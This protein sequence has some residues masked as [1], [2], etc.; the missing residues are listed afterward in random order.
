M[1][2]GTG[3][4]RGRRS[5]P[6]VL[7]G[8]DTLLSARGDDDSSAAAGPAAPQKSPRRR[9]PFSRARRLLS[10]PRI[11]LPAVVIVV[12]AASLGVWAATRSTGSAG[13]TY[14][15]IP[16]V[17]T[18]IRQTL[19]TSGTIQ[20]ATTDTLSFSAAGQVTAVDAQVGQRVTTG[21]TLATMDSPTLKAQAAQ[22]EAG[23]AGAQSQLSQDQASSASSAQLAADQASVSAAQSQA[24]SAN[25]AL[26]GATLTAPIDGIVVTVGLTAG[27]QMSGGSGGGSGSGGGGS[28]SDGSGSGSGG[29][30][31]GGGSGGTS[32]GSS[33]SITVISANDIINANVDATV[34]GRI[35]TGD[36]AVITTQNAA[37]PVLGTVASIGLVAS[38]SSGVATFPVVINVTGPPS[39]RYEG[40]SATLSIIYNQ[41]SNVLAVPAAAVVFSGGKIVVY[42]MVHGR[43]VAKDVTTGRTSGGLTQITRGLTAGEQVVVNIPR[44][45]GGS[46]G[47][48]N[49]QNGGGVIIG[50]RGRVVQIGGGGFGPGG[51]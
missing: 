42:T 44:A 40:A 27:Q 46:G 20:P 4:R 24:D 5:R 41:L 6:D 14:R 7:T 18:T 19:S 36:Q 39:G 8:I 51:G 37:G 16:A 50:P 33:D 25:A 1:N 48:G 3:S 32:S 35:K 45:V 15:V 11:A 26:G 29:G 23:L 22:A 28:G 38:T 17:T 34:V 21:Q 9:N 31:S 47:A 13:P 2:D 43:Q 30:D 10:R 12:A 49:S